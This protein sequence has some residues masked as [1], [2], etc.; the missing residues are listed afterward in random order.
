MFVIYNIFISIINFFIPVI[1]LFIP[2]LKERASA[3]NSTVD[4]LLQPDYINNAVCN[5]TI[6]F[7]EKQKQPIWIHSASM[8]EF[9]QAK[10]L[11]ELLKKN[12]PSIQI[13]CTFFSPSGYNTQKNYEYTDAICYLPIDT[14]WNA[15]KFIN[16]IKPVAA[17][18]VRYE[19]W[20]NYLFILKKNNIP[21][22]LINATFP[23]IL[24]KMKILLPFYKS[25][26]NLISEIFTVSKVNFD[27]FSS[28][29][30]TTLVHHSADTRNDRILKKVNEAKLYPV[31]NR[32]LFN[33]DEL[34]FVCGSVWN[35]DVDIIFDSISMYDKLDKKKIKLI[36]VPHEPTKSHI[37][38]IQNK[39]T[40]NILLS[41]ITDKK[42]PLGTTIIVDSIGKLLKLYGIAD[43]SYIGGAFGVGVHSIA[44]PA[45]YGIP[46]ITGA[47]CFNS[48]DTLPLMDCNALTRIEN[49]L[50]LKDWLVQMNNNINRI[51]I[52]TVAREYIQYNT[53]STKIIYDRIIA[54]VRMLS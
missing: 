28:L 13:L 43:L 46:L 21:T 48:S 37:S 44:E 49:A 53:G 6:L 18:F 5:Q 52:G 33:K 41:Q 19:L 34:I 35:E 9:E 2:K 50:Q 20:Y 23:T 45:G 42:I 22:F 17:V 15:K 24:K 31:I 4:C 29:K 8:G 12:N 36:L 26:F 7:R 14:Y 11:I 40:N 39:F 30:T 47:N 54:V 16:K 38:Y 10:P 51:K 32:K 27:L 1:S 25:I 3:I